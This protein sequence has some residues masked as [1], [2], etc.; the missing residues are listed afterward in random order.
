VLA[1]AVNR[2]NG[3][4]TALSFANGFILISLKKYQ[5]KWQAYYIA[6]SQHKTYASKKYFHCLSRDRQNANCFCKAVSPP[7]NT[8]Y[9]YAF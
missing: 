4:I 1:Q 5:F 9:N 7:L 2:A 6:Y 3:R 8:C